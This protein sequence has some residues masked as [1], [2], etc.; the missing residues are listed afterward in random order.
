MKI[1]IG[2]G[3]PGNRYLFSRHNLGFLLIDSLCNDDLFQKKHNSLIKRIKL[4]GEMVLLAKP[5]TYMNLSG[6]AVKEIVNFYKMSLEDL[7][8]VHDD[9]DLLFGAMKLQKSRGHGGHNGVKN[10]H[11]QL[12]SSGYCRLKMGISTPASSEQKTSDFVLSSFNEA[13]QK[14]LPD[15]LDRARQALESWIKEG[16]QKTENLFNRSFYSPMPTKKDPS[17]ES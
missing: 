17:P 1:I 15:L 2:L 3:N 9:K 14:Q 11:Q 4:G 13:E 8:L 16:F 5:Q 10:I 7:M 6:T 12:D